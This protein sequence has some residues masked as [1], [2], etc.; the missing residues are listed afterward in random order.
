MARTVSRR[1]AYAVAVAVLLAAAVI[2]FQLFT[3][4]RLASPPRWEYKVV[5]LS[6]LGIRGTVDYHFSYRDLQEGLADYGAERW[7]LAAVHHPRGTQMGLTLPAGVKPQ[8]S[9]FSGVAIFKR[10]VRE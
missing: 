2:G 5:M 10:R 1:P 6:E 7:E 9:E 8:G 3:W 4:R